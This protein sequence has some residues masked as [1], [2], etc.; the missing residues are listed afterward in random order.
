MS[1]STLFSDD[2]VKI[3]DKEV[4]PKFGYICQLYNCTVKTKNGIQDKVLLY[5]GFLPFKF[6]ND[7]KDKISDKD[8]EKIVEIYDKFNKHYLDSLSIIA[9]YDQRYGSKINKDQCE[10]FTNIINTRIHLYE[11]E[12]RIKLV[13]LFEACLGLRDQSMI[14]RYLQMEIFGSCK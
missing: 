11:S 13:E 14:P 12:N 8:I 7:L 9:L 6:K 5:Q 2:V 4:F 10:E 1:K 3:L